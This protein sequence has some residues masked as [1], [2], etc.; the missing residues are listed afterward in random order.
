VATV[1]LERARVLAEAVT[2]LFPAAR[3]AWEALAR[4]ARAQGDLA[5]ATAAEAEAGLVGMQPP[6][7]G[8]EGKAMA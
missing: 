6:L 5:R 7:F 4:V 2:T 3:E 8:V 1:Q